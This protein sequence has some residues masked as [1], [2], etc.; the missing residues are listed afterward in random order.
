M[1]WASP[2]DGYLCVIGLD[3]SPCQPR[4]HDAAVRIGEDCVAPWDQVRPVVV[5]PVCPASCGLQRCA[6]VVF[7]PRMRRSSSA[8]SLA[9]AS[10]AA[11]ACWIFASRFS[12]SLWLFVIARNSSFTY[13]GKAVDIK[14][15]GQE[16]GVRYVL[17]GSVRKAG[18]R[19][20][21]SGQLIDAMTDAHLWADR[22][23]GSMED[24]FELQDKVALSVAGVIEPALQ[25][26]EI[27]RSTAR[28]TSDLAAY[29]LY[30]SRVAA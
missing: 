26:A 21:I 17:E 14:Q 12:L 30:L 19:L 11:I 13:K 9:S 3:E 25:E 7:R 4:L 27:R 10:S 20:R 16:L 2:S 23:D 24:V 15:V 1:I 28:P 6:A 5:P 8:A 29:D 22:F 18:A